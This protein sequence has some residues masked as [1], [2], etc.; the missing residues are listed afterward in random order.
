MNT[1]TGKIYDL[2][3][4][5]KLSDLV[6][7]IDGEEATV[8][9][10]KEFIQIKGEGR[11]ESNCKRCHGTG[12]ERVGSAKNSRPGRFR[13]CRCAFIRDKDGSYVAR[14]KKVTE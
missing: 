8:E 9:R 11:V 2:Q 5:E 7:R 6:K 1:R 14:D 4:N 13:P 3:P 10:L 12:R